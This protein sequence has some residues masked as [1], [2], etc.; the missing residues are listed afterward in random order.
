MIVAVILIILF[1]PMFNC[2]GYGFSGSLENGPVGRHCQ[3]LVDLV[4]HGRVFVE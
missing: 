4:L 3:S 2:Y 1:F